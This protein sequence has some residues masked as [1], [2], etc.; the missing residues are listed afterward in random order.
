MDTLRTMTYAVAGRIARM[1]TALTCREDARIS[2][3]AE[4]VRPVRTDGGPV[5][6]ASGGE[7]RL[8]RELDDERIGLLPVADR[9]SEV[10]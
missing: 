4:R 8:C 7:R 2:R 10:K 1:R 9:A 6:E 5:P 3:T